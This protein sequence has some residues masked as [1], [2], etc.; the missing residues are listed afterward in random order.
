MIKKI[1]IV[2]KNKKVISGYKKEIIRQGYAYSL[3]NADVILCLGGDG[4]FLEAERKYPGVPKMLIRDSKVCNKCNISIFD[5][6][7]DVITKNKYEVFSFRKLEAY[8]NQKKVG[9][10]AANDVIIRNSDLAQ[11]IRFDLYIDKKKVFKKELIGDG[12]ITSTVF[13]SDAYFKSVT[14]KSFLKGVGVALNNVSNTSI[15]HK[16][17]S[18]K[19][20]VKFIIKRGRARV[21]FDNSRKNFSIKPFDQVVMRASKK[22][23]NIIRF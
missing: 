1:G 2:A 22:K 14:K 20:E 6:F 21:A 10:Y 12:V 18:E 9:L 15:T 8:I 13:G 23:A 11:A 17:F 7:L 3:R 19:S 4:T 16:L 5:S